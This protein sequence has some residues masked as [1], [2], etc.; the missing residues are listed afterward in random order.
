ME[1]TFPHG[2]SSC[3][4]SA[5]LGEERVPPSSVTVPRMPCTLNIYTNKHTA[6]ECCWDFLKLFTPGAVGTNSLSSY[7]ICFLF[8]N[9]MLSL[10][11]P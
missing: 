7:L 2:Y 5:Y 3:C 9:Y 8:L 10:A 11:L 1:V 6:A 4:V